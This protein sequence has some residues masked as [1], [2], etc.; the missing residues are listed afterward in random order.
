MILST[1]LI[2]SAITYTT[3]KDQVVYEA[4]K[5]GIEPELVLAI[6]KV[7]S[8]FN[9]MAIGKT[10]KERGLM[11]LRPKYFKASFNPSENIQ[12]GISYL[13]KVKRLCKNRYGEAW[14]VCFNHGPNRTLAFV[15]D[16]NYYQKVKVAYGEQKRKSSI[17]RMCS[18]QSSSKF[19]NQANP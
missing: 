9:Y 19:C 16:S 2:S 11:Q 12:E 6:I 15:K 4:S 18:S 17:Y 14:F 13:A 3:I 10:H 1:L 5:Y 8:N 7:E